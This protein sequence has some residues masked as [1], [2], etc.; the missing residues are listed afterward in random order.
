MSQLPTRLTQLILCIALMAF[1]L[2]A[3][4]FVLM[5]MF[6]WDNPHVI[7]W[8][9]YNTS[10]YSR[11]W[12]F[13]G[14]ILLL[15]SILVY[16][17][18][19]MARHRENAD[20]RTHKIPVVS[21][22]LIFFA[23]LFLCGVHFVILWEPTVLTSGPWHIETAHLGNHIYHLDNQLIIDPTKDTNGRFSVY[24]C[25]SLDLLCRKIYTIPHWIPPWGS[26]EETN[27]H[28]LSDVTTNTLAVE[29]NGE[30]VYRHEG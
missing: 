16:P 24:E 30:I 8:L 22:F 11:D 14:L 15:G 9:A 19:K 6:G 23:N 5:Q 2:A 10:R 26:S 7:Y 4:L 12:V 13:A 25:D 29:V 17:R 20:N 27:P 3:I 28:L 21:I 1:C 18:L